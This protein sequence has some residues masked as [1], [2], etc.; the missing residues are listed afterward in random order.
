MDKTVNF[1]TFTSVLLQ[2]EHDFF[3]NLNK[4]S[5]KQLE[6]ASDTSTL[7]K[8]AWFSGVI[9]K[10]YQGHSSYVEANIVGLQLDLAGVN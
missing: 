2:I 10:P 3:H 7:S 1:Y 6:L 8:L 9:H 5:L 4:N